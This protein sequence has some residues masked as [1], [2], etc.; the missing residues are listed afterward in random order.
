MW[1]AVDEVF[2]YT[3]RNYVSLPLLLFVS[4]EGD[5]CS[6]TPVIPA[7]TL[8]RLIPPNLLCYMTRDVS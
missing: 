3:A 4:K 7:P 2:G 8:L 6:L 5:V 1:Y